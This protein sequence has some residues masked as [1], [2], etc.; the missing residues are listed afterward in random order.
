[1]MAY[2][3]KN[4]DE[5]ELINIIIGLTFPRAKFP[6]PFFDLGYEV[7]AVEQ[8]FINSSGNTV[9]PDLIIANEEK[10]F[11]IIFEAK[12]G[13]NAEKEQLKNYEEISDNDLVFNA[14]FNRNLLQNGYETSY[15]CYK[16][17][18]IKD[19]KI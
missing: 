16:N 19:Q 5:N 15:V 10:K 4:R 1:M 11:L 6:H 17:T 7:K 8:T 2:F 14:G 18:Y 12:S 9:K 13:K 3:D